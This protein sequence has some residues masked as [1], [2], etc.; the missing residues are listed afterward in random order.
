M[1][2]SEIT[3]EIEKIAARYVV[4]PSIWQIRVARDDILGGVIINLIRRVAAYR[5][6]E[7]IRFPATWWDAV[8]ERF[9][10]DW[11]LARWPIQYQT[12]TASAML[13]DVPLPDEQKQQ[14]WRVLR[15]T[16]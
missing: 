10:P 16:L 5:G 6:T 9:A 14:M 15:V 7:V 8:K 11:M 3:L 4:D 2:L 1:N 13:P 12:I